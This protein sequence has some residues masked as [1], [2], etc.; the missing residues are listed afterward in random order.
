MDFSFAFTTSSM[1]PR[2]VGL[3]CT[4]E[5]GKCLHAVEAKG[6]FEEVAELME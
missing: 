3:S 5:T 6:L 2:L 4:L 1:D